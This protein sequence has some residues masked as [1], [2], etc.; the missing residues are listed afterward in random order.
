M[1]VAVINLVRS[2]DRRERMESNL[3]RIGLR[4]DFFA[5]IDARRGE[6][7][8]VSQ[9]N[10]AVAWRDLHRPMAA[11]EIGCFASH[12]LLWQRCRAVREP[13]VIMEDDVDV[14]EDFV[15]ALDA[16]S[17][18][19]SQFP[20]IRLGLTREGDDTAS[21]LCLPNAFELVSLGPWTLGTQCY[22]VS[23]IGARAL[24]RHAA[25]WSLPVDLYLDRAGIHGIRNYGLRPYFV[26]HA[27][28]ARL[29]S[30]IGDERYGHWPAEGSSAAS[31]A[32]A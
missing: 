18:L 7:A 6:H 9:Y 26:R 5:G 11:G 16:A 4:F 31:G 24:V 27:D 23:E 25:V 32:R 30:V 12:Y 28:S 13:L 21:V 1:K 10:E 3:A 20:L 8:S 29:P 14:D 2:G 17:K 15:L 19:M 22:I